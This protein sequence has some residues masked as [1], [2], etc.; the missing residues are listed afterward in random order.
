LIRHLRPDEKGVD[1]VKPVG[2]ALTEAKI[3]VDLGV[4]A[5]CQLGHIPIQW[6]R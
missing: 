6:G 5:D 3:Q 2:T 1:G 4:G